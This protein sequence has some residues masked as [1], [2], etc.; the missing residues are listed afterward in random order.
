M[1]SKI[2]NMDYCGNCKILITKK[3]NS[4]SGIFILN[5]DDRDSCIGAKLCKKC[6]LLKDESDRIG[7]NK[8]N[9]N[10]DNLDNYKDDFL[11]QIILWQKEKIEHLKKGK[12]GEYY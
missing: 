7:R 5:P 2:F 9:F 8:P 10:Y 12:I 4:G 1:S 3:N 6:E 11:K